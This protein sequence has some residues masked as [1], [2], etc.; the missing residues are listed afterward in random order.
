MTARKN[1][2]FQCATPA[3]PIACHEIIQSGSGGKFKIPNNQKA[4][5]RGDKQNVSPILFSAR[6]PLSP[7]KFMK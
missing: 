3:L 7:I 5:K 1:Q 4:V 2:K 6:N